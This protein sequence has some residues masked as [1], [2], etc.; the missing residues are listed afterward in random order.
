MFAILYLYI[1]L[2][3]VMIFPA[4]IAVVRMYLHVLFL[5]QD[6]EDKIDWLKSAVLQLH[7]KHEDH[8][9]SIKESLQAIVPLLV[10]L[11]EKSQEQEQL[12]ESLNDALQEI[13][14][15]LA[16]QEENQE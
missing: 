3:N 7:E 10:K 12:Q 14:A 4:I 16:R 2:H 8:E 9:R 6:T 13:K 11:Q 1:L 5:L 15:T